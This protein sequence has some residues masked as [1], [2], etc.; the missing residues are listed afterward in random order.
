[1][2]EINAVIDAIVDTIKSLPPPCQLV[3]VDGRE[4]KCKKCYA[5]HHLNSLG[6]VAQLRIRRKRK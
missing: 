2:S 5:R 3:L 4:C 1:M 6:L